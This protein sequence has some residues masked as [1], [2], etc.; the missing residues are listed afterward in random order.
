[1]TSQTTL[2][3]PVEFAGV[4]IHTGQEGR[5]RV[6]PAPVDS[7]VRFLVAGVELPAAPEHVIS[8]QRCTML[9]SR[10][11]GVSV[12][13]IEHLM[14]ALY[15]LGIDNARVEVSG[16]EIPILDGSALPFV[17]RFLS[18]GVCSQDAPARRLQLSEPLWVQEPPAVAPGAR[19]Q[20]PG[21]V[22]G[23]A[24]SRPADR[25]AWRV[26][27][28]AWSCILAL[29]ADRLIVTA[30]T[31]FGRKLSGPCVYSVAL[32]EAAG[33]FA[34]E[35]APSRTFCFQDEV[36]ALLAAGIGLGGSVENTVVISDTSTS[37]PLRFADE[38]TRHKALDLLGDLALVGAR[39][40]GHFIAL[41]AG[42]T[43]HVA[44]AAALRDEERR[45]CSRSK[46][47]GT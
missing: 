1:M 22:E 35:L 14:A 30:A 10:D 16:P 23:Q 27:P 15:G 36:A 43:L 39:L 11:Q 3:G 19:H 9:G 33:L 37:T 20:A 42:H 41:R 17:E 40:T 7:G 31:D 18:A 12:S 26:A 24:T 38:M 32:D 25:S 28:G 4:G 6:S 47:S 34:S 5:V 21:P 29:P 13:T 46:T 8:T 45:A 44:A 2:A